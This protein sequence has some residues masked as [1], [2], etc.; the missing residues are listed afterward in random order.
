MCIL[1]RS[2]LGIEVQENA[3]DSPV[4]DFGAVHGSGVGW[5]EAR[6]QR[7]LDRERNGSDGRLW[8]RPDPTSASGQLGEYL[9]LDA[10]I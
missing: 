3:K 8:W 10:W 5:F 1:G 9:K 7:W 4:C 6:G 2:Q